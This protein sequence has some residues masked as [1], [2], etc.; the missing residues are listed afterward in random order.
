MEN[1]VEVEVVPTR[2]CEPFKMDIEVETCRTRIVAI[3]TQLDKEGLLS[4]SKEQRKCHECD[5]AKEQE[6]K[7]EDELNFGGSVMSAGIPLLNKSLVD[8]LTRLNNPELKGDALAQEIERSKAVA[9]VSKQLISTGR[10]VVDVIKS[11][12]VANRK[13]FL[14]LEDKGSN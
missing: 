9:E 14:Q 7:E 4:L 11:V 3:K 12:P 13:G 1:F 6:T 2:Y 8:Q 10:L 5:T